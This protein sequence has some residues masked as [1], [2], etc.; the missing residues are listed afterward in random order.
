MMK[1]GQCCYSAAL[2]LMY[3]LHNE[4]QLSGH[5]RAGVLSMGVCTDPVRHAVRDV[6]PLR[7]AG[8][9]LPVL[10]GVPPHKVC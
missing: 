6:T 8:V 4:K 10:G 5:K 7:V 9:S 2:I 3:W 1:R